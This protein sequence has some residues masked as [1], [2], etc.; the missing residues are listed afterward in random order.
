MVCLLL[1]ISKLLRA[2]VAYEFLLF[3]SSQQVRVEL[4][5]HVFGSRVCK[6]ARETF[7]RNLDTTATEDFEAVFLLAFYRV[8]DYVLA[9]FAHEFFTEI[10]CFLNK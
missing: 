5:L 9:D 6:L 8:F 7:W 3:Q 4:P 1:A 10:H 2:H